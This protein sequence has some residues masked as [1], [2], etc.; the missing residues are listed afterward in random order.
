MINSPGAQYVFR[1][2]YGHRV[3][4][5]LRDPREVVISWMK[6]GSLRDTGGWGFQLIMGGSCIVVS[7]RRLSSTGHR[8]GLTLREGVQ[9]DI[10][11]SYIEGF[12]GV[13]H[14]LN[15][16]WVLH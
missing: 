8:A 4:I 9:L 6:D 11:E 12:P 3:G 13:Y 7:P 5:T 16:G 10:G 1:Y 2:R 15:I 14:Q